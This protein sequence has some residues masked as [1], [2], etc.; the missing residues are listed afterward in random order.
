MQAA[1]RYAEEGGAVPL[2]LEAAWRIQDVGSEAV[3]GKDVSAKLIRRISLASSVYH[4]YLSRR[5]YRDDKGVNNWAE[6][7][8]KHPDL[9]RLLIAASDNDG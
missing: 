2:E 4:A 5:D 1:Y 7:A 6:W 3:L 9:N 8:K